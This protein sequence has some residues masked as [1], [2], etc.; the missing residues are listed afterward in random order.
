MARP[1]DVGDFGE[2]IYADLAPLAYADE[3]NDWALLKLMG[4]MGA[5]FE[6]I[7]TLTVDTDEDGTNRPGWAIALDVDQCPV[8]SLPWLAQFVGARIP[9]GLDEETQRDLIRIPRGR[10]RGTRAAMEADV[11]RTLTGTKTVY[12][13]ERVD[14]NA[15]QLTVNTIDSETPD[16]VATLAAII[17]QKPAGI[18]LTFEA[19]TSA[20][21]DSLDGTID[22]LSGTIDSL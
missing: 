5:M 18:V 14:G 20:I 13:D 9:D 7:Y 17:G 1:T 2:L 15:W 8:A 3:D 19:T 22:G 12:I 4:A 6:P 16:E 21:I 10:S 11:Q